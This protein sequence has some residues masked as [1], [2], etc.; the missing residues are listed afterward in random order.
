MGESLAEQIAMLPEAEARRVLGPDFKRDPT[1]LYYNWR[2]W[3][4]PEQLAPKTP[5]GTWLIQAGRGFGKTR[6]GAEWVRERARANP[7]ELIGLVGRTA[8]DVRDVM[9]EGV[10]GILKTSPPDFRPVYEPSKRRLTWPNGAQA[11]TFSADE[12]N[13]LRGPQH[14]T[15][16]ADELAAWVGVEA[17]DNITFGLRMG[18]D[19][20][21]IVTTTPRPTPL[22]RSVVA[23][24]GTI[25]TR[26]STYDNRANL[27][28]RFIQKIITKYAGTRLG[29]QEI[30]GEI[31]DDVPGALWTYAMLEKNRVHTAP[32]LRRIV[33]A[34]DP[35]VSYGPDSDETGMIA[36][37]IDSQNPPH[38]Y[39]LGDHSRRSKPEGWAAEAVAW[40]KSIKADRIVAE[41]NNG[42][43]LVESVIRTVDVN[44]PYR[45]VH[46]SKGKHTRAE[47]ISALYEQGR[48]HHVGIHRELED[49]MTTWQ[50]LVDKKSP[51]RLDAAVWALTDL[52]LGTGAEPRVRT[53]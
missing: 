52:M 25:I 26:G 42:G 27:A 41:V 17:W 24:A 32:V 34:I 9:V 51:D 23:E 43:D 21:V 39:V 50:P 14:S 29:R 31:L 30:D 2:F 19:P 35:A 36:A 40:M 5:W 22:I 44:T 3:G 10:A 45:S 1:S 46:A 37:G 53:L 12:A 49:Q 38:A 28:K 20:R 15:V 18:Q 4:R 16:W 13:Q 11:S 7:E 8:A 6:A 47:P 48:V 33:I